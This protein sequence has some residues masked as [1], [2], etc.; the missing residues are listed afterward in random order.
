MANFSGKCVIILI[1]FFCLCDIV[2]PIVVIS[3]GAQFKDQIECGNTSSSSSSSLINDI[4]ISDWMIIYGVF[5]LFDFF[6]VLF[7]VFTLCMCKNESECV[8][9]VIIIISCF[10]CFFR[11]VWLIVGSVMFWRNCF[12]LKPGEVNSL[13]CACLIIGYIGVLTHYYRIK[14]IRYEK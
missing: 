2:L 11:F 12:N 14:S 3:Y 10:V 4:G 7:V 13:M 1:A 9:I 5:G 8:S 6:S